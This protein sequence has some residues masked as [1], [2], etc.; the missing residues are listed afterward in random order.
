[1]CSTTAPTPAVIPAPARARSTRWFLWLLLL[2]GAVGAWVTYN[3]VS[4]QL[5]AQAA[6]NA[7]RAADDAEAALRRHKT[8]AD[9]NSDPAYLDAARQSA[10]AALA[11]HATP[12]R[13]RR[14]LGR[15]GPKDA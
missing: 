13:P 2:I 15:A 12:R 11:A 7:E 4:Q 8:D 10:E 1:M 9:V 3:K 14:G 6:A 5:A